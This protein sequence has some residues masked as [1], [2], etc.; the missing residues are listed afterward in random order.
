MTYMDPPPNMITLNRK[1]IV[2]VT[3]YLDVEVSDSEFRDVM[4][5]QNNNKSPVIDLLTSEMF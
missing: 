1:Y 4:F 3:E 5:S 2:F